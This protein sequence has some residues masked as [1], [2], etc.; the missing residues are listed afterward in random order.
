MET[1]DTLTVHDIIEIIKKRRW[2]LILPA[3]TIFIIA[4]ALCLLL[5]PVYR[6]TST[7]LIEDQDVSRDYVTAAGTNLVEQ[8]LQM[9]NQRIMSSSRLQEIINRFKLYA[10]QR[11]KETTEEI[12]DRMRT[13]DIKFAPITAEVVDPRSGRPSTATLAFSVSYEGENPATVQGVTNVLTSLYLEENIKVREQQTEGAAKFLEN[14]LNGVRSDLTELEKKIAVYK[15]KH[16]Q[17]IP[18]RFQFNLQTLDRAER[19]SDQMKDQLRALREKESSYQ[20]QLASI[21]AASKQPEKPDK[22]DVLRLED[23]R[24]KLVNLKTRVSDEYPDVIKLKAEIAEL[25]QRPKPVGD[26]PVDN[27]PPDNPIYIT[28]TAQLAST[29]SEIESV[30]RQLVDLNLKKTE[31]GRRLENSPR[32]EE[33]YK[34]I[35]VE[36]N[37]TQIK[38]DDLMK[39]FMEAK[40]AR[41]LEKG[42]MGQRFTLLN[43]AELPEKPVKP[44]RLAILLIGLILGIG[45]S[46]GAASLLEY[47]DHS[48]RSA[49][50]LALATGLAVL[51]TIPEIIK[52]ED[53]AAK[54]KKR[55]IITAS[56]VLLIII[57]VILFHFLVMDLDVFWARLMRRLA[58]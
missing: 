43:P 26:L 56:I 55:I 2:A 48:V 54:M 4:V 11:N 57:V 21:P 1:Q 40:T 36:R 12:I 31:Y 35:L 16:S 22:P 8:R 49:D 19:D 28:L 14:E 50:V 37:N 13:K 6:S 18:E 15:E 53:T 38:Y 44:N 9:I 25:E 7:I 17:A 30:K 33:G 5:P 39:K 45:S 41:G 3:L 47:S 10:D 52:A 23:L 29:T 24:L 32:V 20:S 34:N 58:I 42:Q 46:V 51:A 27:P